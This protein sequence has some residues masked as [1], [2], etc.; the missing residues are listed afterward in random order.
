VGQQD[1][2]AV[3]DDAVGG[4]PDVHPATLSKGARR[5][6]PLARIDDRLDRVT[7]MTG[8]RDAA[9]EAAAHGAP[10]TTSGLR[11]LATEAGV[12]VAVLVEG[13]SDRAAV[14]ALAERDGRDLESE[15]ACVIPLGGATSIYR[16]LE[17]LG[18]HG[19]GLR[20]LGLCDAGEER[21]FR[22]GLERAGLGSDD[23]DSLGFFVCV[24]DLEDELI[25]AAGPGLV[26]HVIAAEG[27]LTALRTLQRQP[28]QRDRSV[29]QQLHRFMGSIGGRKARYAR[30]LVD[31]VEADRVPRP[32]VRLLASI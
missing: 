5:A 14:E 6:A 15:G 10:A 25:R 28:A 19:A 24:A 9:I 11:E 4:D 16:F 18:P 3:D 7:G 26:E 21:Y 20:L 22:R 12:T 23:L 29:D 30:A 8:F 1:P 13:I 17:V 27:D 31:A 32:L 2:A